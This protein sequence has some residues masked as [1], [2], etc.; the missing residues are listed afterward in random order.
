[1]VRSPTW[2][3]TTPTLSTR[4]ENSTRVEAA[5]SKRDRVHLG[6][7]RLE[8]PL[9][10][11][12]PSITTQ[13]IIALCGAAPSMV[14]RNCR[15]LRGASRQHRADEARAIRG[16]ALHRQPHGRSPKR[17][18][19]KKDLNTLSTASKAANRGWCSHST[20]HECIPLD[21]TK[22]LAKPQETREGSQATSHARDPHVRQLA[23][24]GQARTPIAS[25]SSWGTGTRRW[26][27][28]TTA[29]S[30][31]GT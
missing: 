28:A 15:G 12:T 29:T 23:R 4:C 22:P 20:A 19:I 24:S 21:T 6:S 11:G 7:G 30:I 9:P 3:S 2:R 1:M 13:L 31:P 18:T 8:R 25:A 16:R 10:V 17:A 27:S 5:F 26:S 14:T